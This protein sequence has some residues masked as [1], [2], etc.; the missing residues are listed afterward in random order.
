M[1]IKVTSALKFR[2]LV[3]DKY[4]TILVSEIQRVEKCINSAAAQ[5]HSIVTISSIKS[6]CLYD[7]I[8]IYKKNG[9]KTEMVRDQKLG[10]YLKL[11]TIW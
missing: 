2:K 11:T 9:W 7:I 5:K 6:E 4:T 1:D 8:E 3:E 10:D